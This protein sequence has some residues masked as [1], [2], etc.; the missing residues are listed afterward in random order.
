MPA[1]RALAVF[2]LSAV[3]A[4]A[5][6]GPLGRL[7]RRF[8]PLTELPATPFCAQDAALVELGF[9][10]AAADLAWVQMLEYM[11]N[12]LPQLPDAPGHPYAHIAVLASR[13]VSLDP[14]FHRAYLY[15]ASVLGWFPQVARPEQAVALL[16]E[17]LRRDPGQ[18]LYLLYIAALAY[19]KEG[20]VPKMI[21][22]LDST[23]KDP[24]TPT[25]MK[26]ILANLYKSQGR[27]AK[28]L[29]IWRD[30]LDDPAAASDH[31]RARL[32]IE[33]IRALEAAG[34]GS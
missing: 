16:Q 19:K 7:S 11:G 13:I 3:V 12:G 22:L 33:E 17:G 18:R 28:A 29:E 1:A 31:P 20:D 10:A 25:L 23:L 34:R 9:R 4:V 5:V 30:I 24:G 21:A 14:S 27:Y 32:Q 26:E 8:P 2:A 15:G 6:D